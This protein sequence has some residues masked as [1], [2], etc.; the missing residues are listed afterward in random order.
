M[1]KSDRQHPS[2]LQAYKAALPATAVMTLANFPKGYVDETAAKRVAKKLKLHLASSS[3]GRGMGRAVGTSAGLVTM[4][5]FLSGIR[6]IKSGDPSRKRVGTAKLIV[7]SGG[8]GA[9]KGG[10]EAYKA[11]KGGMKGQ[12]LN[13]LVKRVAGTRAVMS[14]GQGVLTARAIASGH[15]KGKDSPLRAA[16]IGGGLGLL[17]GMAEAPTELKGG[18]R[19][20]LDKGRSGARFNRRKLV[21]LMKARGVGRAASGVISGLAIDQIAKRMLG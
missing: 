1:S 7:A 17:K 13:K 20:V 14:A 15:K 10:Y 3:T 6:D 18:Y 9:G 11:F 16:A 12:A 4:P 8:Y 5:L 2:V 21:K 19:S